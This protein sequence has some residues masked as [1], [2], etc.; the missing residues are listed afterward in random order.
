MKIILYGLLHLPTNSLLGFTTFANPEDGECVSVAFTLVNISEN[1]WL[2]KK[3]E[4]A[5]KVRTTNTPWYNASYESPENNFDPKDLKVV[6]LEV[7]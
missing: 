1:V 3:M 7:E 6:K 2:V 4:N 5:E